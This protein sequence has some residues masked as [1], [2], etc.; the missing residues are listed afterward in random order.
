[1]VTVHCN[2]CGFVPFRAGGAHSF[3]Y[4]LLSSIAHEKKIK[5]I[6]YGSPETKK[7]LYENIDEGLEF[8]LVCKDGSGLVNRIKGHAR[9]KSNLRKGEVLWS[10][11]NQGIIAPAGICSVLTIHDLIPLHYAT[12]PERYSNNLIRG[13]VNR[14]KWYTSVRV[15]CAADYVVTVSKANVPCLKR[16]FDSETA[17]CVMGIPNGFD[18]DGCVGEVTERWKFNKSKNILIVS[19]GSLPHK[20]MATV[21]AI[22][23]RLPE[24]RFNIVGRL[25]GEVNEPNINWLGKVTN[26]ELRCQYLSNS[27][28]LFPS[29]IEGFGL[30]IIEALAYGLPVVATDIDVLR[31]VGGSETLYFEHRNIDAAMERVVMVSTDRD[32]ANRMSDS[33]IEHAKS[34]TWKRSALEYSNLFIRCKPSVS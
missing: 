15:G 17:P 11:L 21:R 5:L 29:V 34:F 4:G 14:L 10:P 7:W 19:S 18:L 12:N 24:Y 33:G 28:L 26:E 1:M 30:P 31:E 2:L 16:V 22:A 9:L 25:A 6:I 13:I 20:G 32:I 3:I 27:V 8:K 23:Q